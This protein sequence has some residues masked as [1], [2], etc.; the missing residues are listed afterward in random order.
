M[1]YRDANIRKTSY[2]HTLVTQD[3]ALSFGSHFTLTM[4]SRGKA[5]KG[6]PIEYRD[7][8]NE[9]IHL[10]RDK[11]NIAHFPT[12]L[13]DMLSQAEVEGYS[14]TCS[15]LPHGRAFTIHDRQRFAEKVM[16]LYFRGTRF[17]S[18][19]RQLNLYGFIRI[20]RRNEDHGAFYHELF[21]RGR[22]DLCARILRVKSMG[23]G[24]RLNR[25]DPNFS[26][27]EPVGMASVHEAAINVTQSAPASSFTQQLTGSVPAAAELQ[28]SIESMSRFLGDW[29]YEQQQ[30]KTFLMKTAPDES[31]SIDERSQEAS[32]SRSVSF[33]QHE[34]QN[35]MQYHPTVAVTLNFEELGIQ[36]FQP[37]VNASAQMMS[38]ESPLQHFEQK[39]SAPSAR[40]GDQHLNDCADGITT[41]A[42]SFFSNNQGQQLILTPAHRAANALEHRNM[43]PEGQI[44]RA[45]ACML[46]QPL[47]D[48]M[49]RSQPAPPFVQ[50]SVG[51]AAF[52]AGAM[53]GEKPAITSKIGD[54]LVAGLCLERSAWGNDLDE[55]LLVENDMDDSIGADSN[56]H[57]THFLQDVD[58]ESS[59]GI[60]CDD[61]R[62]ESELPE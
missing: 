16:P 18:F 6:A 49:R 42:A 30:I 32:A 24:E 8:A 28:T 7:Y 31:I 50:P 55:K 46:K 10:A 12:Q 36:R 21:L 54:K 47:L 34:L 51:L 22:P 58:L 60:C 26:K 48:V 2:M 29:S 20:M 40:V 3:P 15:W 23:S 11:G 38:N 33:P 27:M 62:L 39:R 52:D 44:S 9:P 41:R 17:A 57:M 56:M 45:D 53:V 5:K 14:N 19:H 4:A 37:Q 35:H 43:Q 59:D 13:H 1:V 25:S 61:W